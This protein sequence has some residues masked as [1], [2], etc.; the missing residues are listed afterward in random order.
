MCFVL[1]VGTSKPLPR[2]EWRKDD[3]GTSVESL[4]DRDASIAAHFSQPEVQYV[5]STSGC[6]CDFPHATYQNGGWPEIGYLEHL[7]GED[8]ER[9]ASDRR[10]RE[11][12]VDLLRSSGEQ[13]VELYG[14]WDGDFAQAPA[15]RETLPIESILE[16]NFLLKERGFY[17]VVIN[18]KR[19]DPNA[20]RQFPSSDTLS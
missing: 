6:G 20:A 17:E 3:P 19:I 2:K 14:I 13:V 18:S 4:T 9:I 8:V 1:Y 5:G 16:S 12:L 10:N 11:A 7:K 15:S